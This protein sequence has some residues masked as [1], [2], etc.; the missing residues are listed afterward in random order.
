MNLTTSSWGETRGLLTLPR[1]YK[2]KRNKATRKIPVRFINLAKLPK[3]LLFEASF[4]SRL[5]SL[6]I[7]LK[8]K[9]ISENFSR[10]YD[11]AGKRSILVKERL[12]NCFYEGDVEDGG[13]IVLSVCHPL[14]GVLGI[15]E[16]IYLLHQ[17]RNPNN[18][19]DGSTVY[20]WTELT[21]SITSKSC[22]NCQS[23][24]W[25]SLEKLNGALYKRNLKLIKQDRM[26][27]RQP[28]ILNVALLL[29]H[30]LLTSLN[31]VN[32]PI[33]GETL[34]TAAVADK[35]LGKINIKLGVA[36]MEMWNKRDHIPITLSI[37]ETLHNLVGYW[38]K[39]IRPPRARI[40]ILYTAKDFS[41][42]KQHIA[43]PD[44]LCT[45]RALA[46]VKYSDNVHERIDST[47]HS[48][49]NL[50]GFNESDCSCGDSECMIERGTNFRFC[51]ENIQK[52]KFLKVHAHCLFPYE[53]SISFP[54]RCGNG[55]VERGEECD[56]RSR[57]FSSNRNASIL[58]LAVI[59]TL[60]CCNRGPRV[61]REVAV[62]IAQHVCREAI[63]ECDVPE[64]CN[65]VSGECPH[66][67]YVR[68][69]EICTGSYCYAGE[70]ITSTDQCRAIWG[71]DSEAADNE[72]FRIYNVHGNF[73]G[74][75]GVEGQN[76]KKCDEEN[77][78]CGLLHCRGG[79]TQKMTY[80][81]EAVESFLGS[82]HCKS[83]MKKSSQALVRNGTKC[84]ESSICLSGKCTHL[85]E[86]RVSDCP[87][88]LHRKLCSG[89]GI[90][91][92]QGRCFCNKGYTGESCEYVRPTDKM[93][94]GEIFSL[95]NRPD[96]T[97]A[98]DLLQSSKE[99]KNSLLW[100]IIVLSCGA[101]GAFLC[102]FIFIVCYRRRSPKR[103]QRKSQRKLYFNKQLLNATQNGSFYEAINNENRIIS[104]GSMPTYRKEK[105]DRRQR[106]DTPSLSEAESENTEEKQL[107]VDGLLRKPDRG[108]LKNSAP[109][110]VQESEGPNNIANMLDTELQSIKQTFDTAEADSCDSSSD[111][112]STECN[113]SL[114][115]PT[116]PPP[117]TDPNRS[118]NNIENLLKQIDVAARNLAEA[119]AKA[120]QLSPSSGDAES[121]LKLHPNK[122]CKR[123]PNPIYENPSQMR[124][125]SPRLSLHPHRSP[126]RRSQSPIYA[127]LSLPPPYST[128]SPLPISSLS[129][130]SSSP[131]SNR[132]PPSLL[133]LPSA[134]CK[135]TIQNNPLYEYEMTA[136]GGK[137]EP[138]LDESKAPSV[139]FQNSEGYH[140]DSAT[141][142]HSET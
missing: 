133:P 57:E 105:K 68:D 90:C 142:K 99:K 60:A 110:T 49:L 89:N 37:R 127:P 73:Q 107:A 34:L 59:I 58:T 64:Y 38:T 71:P 19:T 6:K 30:S 114:S 55:I 121:S 111:S 14:R 100:L 141:T 28:D 74:H 117:Q 40:A 63:G 91:S 125:E 24:M 32:L 109:N 119:T 46:V 72:C 31:E 88:G 4:N 23:G 106:R 11:D 124:Q 61:G 112:D 135:M 27:N 29:D 131:T 140:S 126:K 97:Q 84:D 118:S 82:L 65:G 132:R 77:V 2:W 83:L 136:V 56:C 96:T 52:E 10:L 5:L 13:F 137:S 66:N 116:P 98:D 35:L 81:T 16:R 75:C 7:R 76:Y 94:M 80:H 3:R 54:Q 120:Q 85:K 78:R 25:K 17:T 95:N 67:E 26:K 108:I 43:L 42:D 9:F 53:S 130:P 1:F 139:E 87:R 39:S 103:L 101:G 79:N 69:G 138:L 70:C 62:G 21:S 48:I 8:R 102:C 51:W 104:F 128:Y 93:P 18:Q 122:K 45:S 44:S 129:S 123:S 41:D 15:G 113:G 36:Y 50:I 12:P 115:T 86:L 134:S 92:N 22:G 47:F 20:V 33:V